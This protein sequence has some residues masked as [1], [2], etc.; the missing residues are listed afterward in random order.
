MGISKALNWY[1]CSVVATMLQT[2]IKILKWPAKMGDVH[3]CGALKYML[4]LT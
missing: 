3:P 1:I 4:K 2:R